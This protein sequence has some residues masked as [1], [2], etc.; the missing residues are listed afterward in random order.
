MPVINS[1]IRPDIITG[2]RFKLQDIAMSHDQAI[3]S[4]EIKVV[5]NPNNNEEL[6]DAE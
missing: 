2:I 3:N 4:S 1:F 5:V 6:T